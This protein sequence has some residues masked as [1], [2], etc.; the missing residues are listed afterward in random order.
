MC[1][2]HNKVHL[3]D[4][5]TIDTNVFEIVGV[6]GGGFSPGPLSV[7]NTPISQIG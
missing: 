6:G 5:V 7:S 4:M 3:H 1:E 2:T